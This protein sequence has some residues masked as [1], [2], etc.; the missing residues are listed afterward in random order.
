MIEGIPRYFLGCKDTG[1]SQ[2]TWDELLNGELTGE[3]RAAKK[4]EYAECY[5][6]VIK[7][8]KKAGLKA[9]TSEEDIDV[10]SLMNMNSF[11]SDMVKKALTFVFRIAVG[12]VHLI[13]DL[14]P[15][16]MD[17]HT[18]F[19]ERRRALLNSVALKQVKSLRTSH[20]EN[21]FEEL[22]KKL[23]AYVQSKIESLCSFMV[24]PSISSE[25]EN[26]ACAALLCFCSTIIT[27]MDCSVFNHFAVK[28][29]PELRLSAFVKQTHRFNNH[30]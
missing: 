20:Q 4:R 29:S 21:I 15:W 22:R 19:H 1:A 2:S 25:Y 18:S 5:D 17:L 12:V 11:G 9:A 30:L 28:T 16:L 14:R 13:P 24:N 27:L 3:E 8:A 23:F 10:A 7:K 6:N 26:H